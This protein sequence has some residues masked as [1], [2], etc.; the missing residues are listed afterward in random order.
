M[1]VS[2]WAS[3]RCE[4]MCVGGEIHRYIYHHLE[5]ETEDQERSSTEAIEHFE[6]EEECTNAPSMTS[7]WVIQRASSFLGTWVVGDM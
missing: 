2:E 6:P 7:S 5:R 1:R 3:G 4:W